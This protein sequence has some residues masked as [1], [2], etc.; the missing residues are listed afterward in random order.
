MIIAITTAATRVRH[1]DAATSTPTLSNNSNLQVRCG[2]CDTADQCHADLL[3]YDLGTS[4][5]SI[6]FRDNPRMT[7]TL[8]WLPALPPVSISM[9]IYATSTAH[10]LRASSKEEMMAPVKVA[11]TIRRSSQGIRFFEGLKYPGLHIR[12]IAGHDSR[13]FFPYPPWSLLR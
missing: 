1:T 8:A 11:D 9:G 7:V 3:E 13:H 5:Y 10:T 6:S 12:L 4:R 2:R